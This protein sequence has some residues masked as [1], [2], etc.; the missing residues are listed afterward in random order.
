MQ[1][2]RKIFCG[3][4]GPSPVRQEFRVFPQLSGDQPAWFA[5]YVQVNHEKEV[6]L[7]L[8]QKSLDSFLPLHEKWSKRRDRRKRIQVPLF[9]GYV[10]VHTVLDNYVNLDILRTPGV[11]WILRNTSGPLPIP[12]YQIDSLKIMLNQPQITTAVPYLTKGDW[13]QVIGGPFAGCVGVL[14]RQDTR[15]GRLVVNIDIIRQS[16]SV[17]LD[18]EDVEP[19]PPPAL[20]R[21]RSGGFQTR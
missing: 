15:K 4:A 19:I 1:D 13:V 14:I 21:S 5:I 11:V 16:A 10:F 17:E 2:H 7:R 6:N 12:D 3:A 20:S 18:V 9:P 8:Q